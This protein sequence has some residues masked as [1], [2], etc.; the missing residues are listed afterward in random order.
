MRIAWISVF[1]DLPSDTWD[2]GLAFWRSAT[3]TTPSTTRGAE[4]QFLTLLP[5]EGDEFVRV[6]RLAEGPRLHLDLEAVDQPALVRLALDL[7]ATELMR[8]EHVVLASP[9]GFVFCVV[10]DRGHRRRPGPVRGARGGRS[11]VD[12]VA[13]DVPGPL[14]DAERAFWEGLTGWQAGPEGDD[15]LQVLERPDGM[16]VRLLLQRLGDDDGRTRT[17]AHLDL[18]AGGPDRATVEAEHVDLGA[19]VMRRHE[20]W[21]VMRDPAGLEYCLTDRS[22]D[23]GLVAR[24]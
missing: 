12:Q 8:E 7:G 16:P 2:T 3:G 22:P 15:G 14:L 9:G 17:T 10:A 13:I 11:L 21:T 6:Q 5:P 18:A 23:T 20:R 1:L 4:G 19:Q 24:G